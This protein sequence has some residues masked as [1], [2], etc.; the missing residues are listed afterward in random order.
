MSDVIEPDEIWTPF[1][2]RG[3]DQPWEWR[4]LGNLVMYRPRPQID[5]AGFGGTERPMALPDAAAG[6]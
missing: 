1:T 6:K 4:L 3:S 5:S 2:V